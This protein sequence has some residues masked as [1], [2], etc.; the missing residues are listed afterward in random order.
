MGEEFASEAE[1]LVDE[2]DSMQCEVNSF[3][4][5]TKVA[6]KDGEK[7]ISKI[8]IG[9]F[10]LAWNS[11]TNQISFSRV[12]DTIHH[13]DKT[14][15]R[16]TIGDET[17]TTTPE[18]PF[19]V[20]GKGWV[21]AK[22]LKVGDSIRNADGSTG[23]VKKIKIE[24]ST[25]EMYNLTVDQAHTFFVGEGQWLVHNACPKHGNFIKQLEDMKDSSLRRTI[26]S[27]D[28]NI[29]EHLDNIANNPT[30]RDVPHWQSE[31]RTFEEQLRLA[32]KEALRR[33][34]IR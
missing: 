18:H 4:A 25:R 3:S 20:E 21:Y 29:E 24:Q 34:I 14:I 8:Q 27:L 33:G 19:Y 16:L 28:D 13:T 23:K 9:D 10:V 6:T 2:F 5:E 31:I 30:S 17:I 26:R 15:V 7:A 1:V 22:D 32:L 12:T 11:E